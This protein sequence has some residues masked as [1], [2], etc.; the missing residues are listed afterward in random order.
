MGKMVGIYLSNEEEKALDRFCQEHNCTSYS[1]LKGGL[2]FILDESCRRKQLQSDEPIEKS[3]E[4]P[5]KPK[6][7]AS[8][9]PLAWIFSDLE[10]AEKETEESE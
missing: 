9:D 10:N 7:K 8:E 1:V 2:H 3:E 6:K 5:K 4:N